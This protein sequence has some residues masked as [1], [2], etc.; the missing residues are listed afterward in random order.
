M[1]PNIY[2]SNYFILTATFLL[3]CF[4]SIF[5]KTPCTYHHKQPSQN[6]LKKYHLRYSNTIINAF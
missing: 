6:Q 5:P 1:P 4:Q 2:Q 3:V